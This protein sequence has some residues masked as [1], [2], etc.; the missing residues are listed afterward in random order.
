[1]DFSGVIYQFPKEIKFLII[2]FVCTLSIGFYSGIS[3]VKSTTN[4]NPTGIEQRYLGNEEDESATKMMFKKSEGEIMTTVHSHILSL[5]VVFFLIAIILST[6][7]I[8][9]KLKLFLMVEPFISLVLTFGG[10]YFLWKEIHWMK[11]IIMISGFLMT[12]SYTI[13]IFIIFKQVLVS[14]KLAFI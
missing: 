4:A 13:S 8:N 2:A 1:M 10:I 14:K 6:T 7:E 5:S 11:Y 12:M 9:Q 3:F